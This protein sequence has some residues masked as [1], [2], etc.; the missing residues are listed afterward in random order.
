MTT[1]IGADWNRTIK[2][3]EDFIGV[4]WERLFDEFDA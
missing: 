4:G 1:F 3:F 2:S